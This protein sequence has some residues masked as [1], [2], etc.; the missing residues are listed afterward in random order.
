[1]TLLGAVAAAAIAVGAWVS[2]PG[3]IWTPTAEQFDEV[4]GSLEGYVK[5]QAAAQHVTLP[6]WSS[7]SFQYQGRKHHSRKFIY[8]SA[9]CQSQ[10]EA[11]PQ[12]F[13]LVDDGGPCFFQIRYDLQTKMFYRLQFNGVG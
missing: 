7:Y 2:V 6:D 4:H 13:V 5:Q 3:G 10:D 8:I 11:D 1:M 9:L 12:Q